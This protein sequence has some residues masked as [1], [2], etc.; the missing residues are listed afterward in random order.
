MNKS[1]FHFWVRPLCAAIVFAGLLTSLSGCFPLLVGGTVGGAMS[2]ADRRTFG[3]QTEDAT[4]ELKGSNRISSVFGDD[5][6]V[7]VNSY[8]RKV[9]LTGEVKDEATRARVEA[10]IKGI[11]NVQSVVNELQVSLFLPGFSTHSSDAYISTKVRAALV[12]TADIYSK[13][14]KVV[15]E[16]G[17]VYLM[18]RVSQR[19]GNAGAEA[20]RAVSGVQKVVKV[21]EYI[22]ESEVKKYVPEGSGAT[23]VNTQP[24][25]TAPASTPRAIA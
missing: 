20:A 5:V 22:D 6:H 2:I 14:F 9:L 10:E 1:M 18:G 8:N 11:E 24:A 16:A 21:F 15:T 19:E 17:V 23:T 3:A 7:D 4:I 13:S 12:S 25:S